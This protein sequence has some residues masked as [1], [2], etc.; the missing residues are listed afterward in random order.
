LLSRSQGAKIAIKDRKFDKT[1][2]PC[3]RPV[4]YFFKVIAIDRAKSFNLVLVNLLI[5]RGD[6]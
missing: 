2:V 3:R 4:L 1:Y 5:V 6:Y